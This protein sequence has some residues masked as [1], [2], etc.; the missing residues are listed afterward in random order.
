[1]G[2]SSRPDPEAWRR[3]QPQSPEPG[4]PRRFRH[5]LL[6]AIIAGLVAVLALGGLGALLG[7]GDD[8]GSGTENVR[9]E[10]PAVEPAEPVEEPPAEEQQ[11]AEDRA[12]AGPVVVRIIDGDTVDLRGTGDILPEDETSRVRL[13]SIDAP[14]K[15]ACFGDEATDRIAE[16]LPV[17][18]TVRIEQDIELK[19]PYDRYVLYVWNE[20]DEFV[21][22]SL[23]RSGHAEAVRYPPNDKHWV[24]ISDAGDAA[25]AAEAGLWSACPAA[26]PKPPPEPAPVPEPP[27]PPEP[28]P[29]PE[30]PPPPEPAPVPEPEPEPPATSN[31]GGLPPGPPPGPD[32]DCADLPGPVWVGS[33]DPH[34]LDRDND[35]IGCEAN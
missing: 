26:P 5:P 17:G 2:P 33:N 22:E 28:A 32:L 23:V 18:E 8:S 21:N 6:L 25:R 27:P 3:S 20:Q 10:E 12:P 11:P 35:G 13:A 14:E 4:E 31:P 19:D 9:Q 30:P 34:G 15:D 16:L 24:K 7:G 1:M 29:V